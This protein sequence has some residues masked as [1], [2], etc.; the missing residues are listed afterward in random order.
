[1]GDYGLVRS[2]EGLYG[3]LWAGM[4]DWGLEWSI[5]VLNG[6][7]LGCDLKYLFCVP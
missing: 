4:I 7:F 5:V 6:C 1:M 3:R 2:S